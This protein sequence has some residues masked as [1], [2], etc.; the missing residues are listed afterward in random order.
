V[1]VGP[2]EII[3]VEFA[4][5]KFT[6][7]IAPALA[8][9]VERGTI[10]VI[11]LLFVAKDE[12]GQVVAVEL[13]DIGDE[14]RLAFEPVVHEIGGLLS[15]EDVEDLSDGLDSGSSAALLLFEH[16]WATKFRDAVLESGGELVASIR[17]PKEVVDE[18]VAARES[19]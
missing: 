14:I 4:G 8:E 17:V 12:D 16:T 9:L 19:A 5:N 6:G 13:S 18:I 10:R 2:V 7:E 1:D 3:M 11:D 15:E